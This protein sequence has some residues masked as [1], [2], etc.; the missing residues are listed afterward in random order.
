MLF[1]YYY[2]LK[3]LFQNTFHTFWKSVLKISFQK[4]NCENPVLEIM[5]QKSRKLFLE[6][7]HN[8]IKFK[9]HF[10]KR[11]NIILK[12]MV[13]RQEIMRLQEKKTEMNHMH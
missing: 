4:L 2:V 5:F 13:V 1:F 11:E 6:N 7:F 8:K 10:Y 3:N 9:N 12:I